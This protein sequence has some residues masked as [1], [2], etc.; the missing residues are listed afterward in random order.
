MRAEIVAILA[1]RP[2]K[3][4]VSAMANNAEAYQFAQDWYDTFKAAVWTMINDVVTV[5]IGGGT[6]RGILIRLHGETIPSGQ[7][8]DVPRDSAAGLLA[9]SLEKLK[10]S[11]QARA[12]RFLNM[13]K[14]Q[15]SFEVSEQ[16]E[17]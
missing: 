3:I 6:E 2:A 7:K 1:R 4:A 9:E 14:D 5:F 10:M 11:Q 15:L 16:P 17:S 13:P 8:V 12:Q